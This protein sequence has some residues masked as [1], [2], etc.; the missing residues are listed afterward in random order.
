MERNRK[1]KILQG[2]ASYKMKSKRQIL[3]AIHENL[4]DMM[5]LDSI[6]SEETDEL[7]K[8]DNDIIKGMISAREE[9]QIELLSKEVDE[10]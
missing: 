10:G 9:E 7:V 3:E 5:N 4:T 8:I 6:S 1:H 2:S